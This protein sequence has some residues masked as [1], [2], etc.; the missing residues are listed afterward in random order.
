[1]GGCPGAYTGTPGITFTPAGTPP[2]SGNFVLVQLINSD[3]VSY[4]RQAG[5]LTCSF[6]SGLDTQYPYPLSGGKA[7][8]APFTPLPPIYTTASRSFNAT[9]YLMWQSSLNN[10]IPVPLLYSQWQFSGSTTQSSGT[11][12]KPTGSGTVGSPTPSNGSYPAW[13]AIAT[14]TCQ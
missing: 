5:T 8:D 7:T 14:R 10:S 1:M 11:W 9:M 6:N 4:Q 2:G 12:A 13:S 3:S